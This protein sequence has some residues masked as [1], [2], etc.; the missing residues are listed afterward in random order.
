MTNTK[1]SPKTVR[2]IQTALRVL[3]NE[4]YRALVVPG[5]EKQVEMAF[6]EL[7]RVYDENGKVI[8]EDK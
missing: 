2:T 8:A 4:E 3:R 7:D 5:I 1:L 6:E